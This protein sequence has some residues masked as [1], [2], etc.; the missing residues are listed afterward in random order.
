MAKTTATAQARE[1]GRRGEGAILI[2][3]GLSGVMASALRAHAVVLR[4]DA[5]LLPAALAANAVGSAEQLDAIADA[6]EC[7]S[8]T[9][10]VS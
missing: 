10:V 5:K 4:E 8:I 7:E 3:E 9:V 2:D 6:I 1:V